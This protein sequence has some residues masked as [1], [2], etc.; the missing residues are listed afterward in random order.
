MEREEREGPPKE[1]FK[2][3]GEEVNEKT[4][5]DLGD[6][7]EGEYDVDAL[8]RYQLDRLRSVFLFFFSPS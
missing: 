4:V 6:G 8:R 7:E 2:R 1:L 3:K 5:Y